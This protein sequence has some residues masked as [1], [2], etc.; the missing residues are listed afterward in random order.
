MKNDPYDR[1]AKKYAYVCVCMYVC[2]Y[3]YIYI[4]VYMYMYVYIYIYMSLQLPCAFVAS[5]QK[6]WSLR[7]LGLNE[8]LAGDEGSRTFPS[9]SSFGKS[10]G[11]G[12]FQR[13]TVKRLRGGSAQSLRRLAYNDNINGTSYDISINRTMLLTIVHC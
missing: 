6:T 11:L 9:P 8:G 1:F 13:K 10:R 2:M 5:L 7:Y 3:I 4:Y 12:P